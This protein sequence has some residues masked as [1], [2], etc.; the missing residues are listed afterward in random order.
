MRKACAEALGMRI[1]DDAHATELLAGLLDDKNAAAHEAARSC[2][3]LPVGDRSILA[4]LDNLASSDK[5][6]Q[7][8]GLAA[9]AAKVQRGAAEVRQLSSHQKAVCRMWSR[10]DL[11]SPYSPTRERAAWDLLR[12]ARGAPAWDAASFW[13]AEYQRRESAESQL[14][15][16]ALSLDFRALQASDFRMY[17]PTWWRDKMDP[18]RALVP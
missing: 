10:Y 16:L 12:D 2:E 13:I 3:K 17:S 8:R 18:A 11:T 1:I 15:A 14:N 5:D 7:V 4:K 6:D 9:R